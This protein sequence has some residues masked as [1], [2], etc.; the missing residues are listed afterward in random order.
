MTDLIE[1]IW[2]QKRLGSYPFLGWAPSVV[3]RLSKIALKH[4]YIHF[5]YSARGIMK[6]L[7]VMFAMIITAVFNTE[8]SY[9]QN[10]SLPNDVNPGEQVSDLIN[11]MVTAGAAIGGGVIGSLLT[12]RHNRKIE[13]QK[14]EYAKKDKEQER[15]RHKEEENQRYAKLREIVKAEL[16]SYS[17]TIGFIIKKTQ[18]YT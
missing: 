5:F 17:I 12:Y 18:K 15:S 2:F 7:T 9:S 8:M 4:N 14:N 1:C 11:P 10:S 13:E 16:R 6:I 3:N